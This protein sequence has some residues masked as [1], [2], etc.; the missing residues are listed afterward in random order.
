MSGTLHVL[1]GFLGA[2]QLQARA[3]ATQRREREHRE[4]EHREQRSFGLSR[5]GAATRSGRETCARHD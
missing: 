4:Q 2:L 5:L 3:G 1:F